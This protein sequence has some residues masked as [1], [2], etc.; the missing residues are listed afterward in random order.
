M[1]LAPLA[2][3]VGN[4]KYVDEI[5]A[6]GTINLTYKLVYNPLGVMSMQG[7]GT[8]IT[9]T[10]L[11]FTVAIVYRDALGGQHV[12]NTSIGVPIEPFI[13]L[14]LSPDTIAR[15]EYNK[16][17]V[18]GTIINYGLSTAYAVEVFLNTRNQTST[19][20]IGD[21]DPSSQ[22]A[23]RVELKLNNVTGIDRVKLIIRYKDQYSNEFTIYRVLGIRE[24]KLYTLTTTTQ[25]QAPIGIPV[26]HA[27]IL[28]AV[29]VFLAVTGYFI[30]RFLKNYYQ[31][32]Q[33]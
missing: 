26:E 6:L 2:I 12:F 10:S 3:V 19:S 16:V 23:F 7:T 29:G 5:A 18:T 13:D 30:H 24:I 9:Y 21:I 32:L 17:V 28:I 15:I 31:R 25:A 14:D 22:T 27:I 20:F 11:P 8:T 1:P 33:R 4:T